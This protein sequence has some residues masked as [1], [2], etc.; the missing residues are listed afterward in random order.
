MRVSP[1]PVI[2]VGL[3]VV[4]EAQSPGPVVALQPLAQTVRRLEGALVYLGQP[5]PPADH[6]AIANALALPDEAAGAAALQRVLDAHVL[7]TVRIN[8]E[9]RVSIEQGSASPAL[10]EE[11]TRLFLVKVLNQGGVRAPLVVASPQSGATSVPSW[12][13]NL[14]PDP[15]IVLSPAQAKE[16]WADISLYEKSP[17]SKALTG[18]PVE[19]PHP[20]GLQPGRGTARCANRIQRGA[21]QPGH[22]LPER[23]PRGVQRGARA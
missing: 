2:V 13:S 19:Y 8:P 12:T 5:L 6:D 17:F 1:W 7:L 20:R 11:G 4:A 14:S 18:L 16:K 21:G 10:I 15:P 9:S 22:R 23:R 3:A